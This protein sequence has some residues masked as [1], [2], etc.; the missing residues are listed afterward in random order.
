MQNAAKSAPA[1]PNLTPAARKSENENDDAD[2]AKD[3]HENIGEKFGR[4]GLK[5]RHLV[6]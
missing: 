3:G 1:M 5:P 6:S 4:F 2:Q